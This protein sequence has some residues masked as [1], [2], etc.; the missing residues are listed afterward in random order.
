M[1]Y[2]VNHLDLQM[3]C[4]D[5]NMSQMDLSNDLGIYWQVEELK[6][7]V[8]SLVWNLLLSSQ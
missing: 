2:S 6:V 8:L 4:R 3:V 1:F 5:G 7:V